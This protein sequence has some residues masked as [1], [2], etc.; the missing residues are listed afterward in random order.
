MI[1][2]NFFL[3]RSI[4]IIPNFLTNDINYRSFP[5]FIYLSRIREL[6][7]YHRRKLLLKRSQA[8]IEFIE[9]TANSSFS[10]FEI[11]S[12]G[13]IIVYNSLILKF[14]IK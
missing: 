7:N 14:L 12:V 5:H 1:N 13:V 9:W 6:E 3:K 11:S 10:K 2:S 8:T 4:L